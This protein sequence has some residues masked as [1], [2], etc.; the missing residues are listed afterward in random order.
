MSWNNLLKDQMRTEGN[1]GQVTVLKQNKFNYNVHATEQGSSQY[2]H[3]KTHCES[4][5]ANN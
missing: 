4:S 2:D 3:N 5:A 1:V